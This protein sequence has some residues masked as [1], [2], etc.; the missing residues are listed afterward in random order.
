VIRLLIPLVGIPGGAG[1]FRTVS[2]TILSIVLS[3]SSSPDVFAQNAV[4]A[5]LSFY[6]KGGA[7]CFRIAPFGTAL[8]EE[9]EWTIM[10]LTSASNH[11]NTFRV[12]SV[13]PGETG[14][15][16]SGLLTAG[17][18]ANDVWKFDGARADFFQRFA[19]GIRDGKLRARIVKAGPPNLASIAS[20]RERAELYLKFADTGTRVSFEKVPDLSAEEFQQF[21][22][23]FPD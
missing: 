11:H 15:S 2:V 14:L 18:L 13:D 17:R 3:A 20:Q 1:L 21:A 6:S 5:A 4:D 23:Y 10:V 8:S 22:E 16:G 9:T 19:D 7:Y 12:R